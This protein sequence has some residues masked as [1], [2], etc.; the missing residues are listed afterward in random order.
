MLLTLTSCHSVTTNYEHDVNGN[1]KITVQNNNRFWIANSSQVISYDRQ[2]EA[3]MVTQ[4]VGAVGTVAPATSHIIRTEYKPPAAKCDRAPDDPEVAPE[5]SMPLSYE[6]SIL[7]PGYE[8][9][10]CTREPVSP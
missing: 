2:G 9:D 10:P 4:S 3:V 1:P 7:P 5:T 8:I 6:R